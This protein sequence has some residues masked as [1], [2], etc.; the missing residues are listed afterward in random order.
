M[1]PK[2]TIII[3]M[4]RDKPEVTRA[5]FNQRLKRFY[6]HNGEK[7]VGEILSRLVA[8]N[9]IERVRIGVYRLRSVELKS[10]P[11]QLKLL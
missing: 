7:Y 4:L 5:E 3:Q 1:T 11:D 9:I 8:S 10:P 6:Y 2:Q